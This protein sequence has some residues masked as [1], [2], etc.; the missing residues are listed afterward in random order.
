MLY[1]V[2]T[3]NGRVLLI[4]FVARFLRTPCRELDNSNPLMLAFTENKRTYCGGLLKGLL[5]R[6][7]LMDLLVQTLDTM[8]KVANKN[9]L[10]RHLL[11]PVL[12][13]LMQG[14]KLEVLCHV[15]LL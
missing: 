4:V 11:I 5:F 10:S 12:Y 7:L 15:Q 2:T 3:S 13:I 8:H 1:W 14:L 9:S 6:S